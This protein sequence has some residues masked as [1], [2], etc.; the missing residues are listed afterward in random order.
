MEDNKIYAN[1]A[2]SIFEGNEKDIA[3]ALGDVDQDTF[4]GKMNELLGTNYKDI[5][6]FS[7]EQ[8]ST[9]MEAFSTLSTEAESSSA[10]AKT[11]IAEFWQALA[12]EILDLVGGNENHPEYKKVKEQAEAAKREAE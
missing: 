1:I 4:L 11:A 3:T 10:D 5:K 6:D 8:W 7:P 2:R 12:D 9:A